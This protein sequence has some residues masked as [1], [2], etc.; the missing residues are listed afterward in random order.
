M[1]ESTPAPSSDPAASPAKPYKELASFLNGVV[2]V[3]EAKVKDQQRQLEQLKG[4][5]TTNTHLPLSP[6]PPQTGGHGTR[7]NKV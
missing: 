5:R 4:I 2:P 7:T 1:A 6:F 3:F